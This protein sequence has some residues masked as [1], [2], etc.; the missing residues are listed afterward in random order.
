MKTQVTLAVAFLIL[1]SQCNHPNEKSLK[2]IF[3]KEKATLTFTYF[4]DTKPNLEIGNLEIKLDI[5]P[6]KE[7]NQA[8]KQDNY[9][10]AYNNEDEI[11]TRQSLDLYLEDLK[12]YTRYIFDFSFDS[13]KCKVYATEK[14]DI[15][16]ITLLNKYNK[17]YHFTTESYFVYGTILK[18]IDSELK[19]ERGDFED[20][21]IDKTTLSLFDENK[22]FYKSVAKNSQPAKKIKITEEEAFRQIQDAFLLR[23]FCRDALLKLKDSQPDWF[24]KNTGG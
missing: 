19:S 17:T 14:F 15:L 12:K 1:F 21:V 8:L 6:A 2:E 9:A 10:V 4:F 5:V 3:A 13:V 11:K 18:I 23:Q 20:M 22:L 16:H 24:Q 7:L